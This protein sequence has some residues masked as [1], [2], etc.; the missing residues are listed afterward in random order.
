MFLFTGPL[1]GLYHA[2][3]P[4]IRGLSQGLRRPVPDCAGRHSNWPLLQPVLGTAKRE[5][6]QRR[7]GA[8][9]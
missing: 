1:Q 4:G 7:A 3:D 9:L 6:V 2:A 8:K 5:A